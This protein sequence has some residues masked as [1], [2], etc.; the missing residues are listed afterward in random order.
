MKKNIRLGQVLLEE[1]KITEP[2]LEIALQ[3]QKETKGKRLGEI[4]IELGFIQETSML[5]SLAKRLNIDYISNFSDQIDVETTR[6]VSEALVKK[7]NIVPLYIRDGILH[8]A[9]NDPLNFYGIDDIAMS[10][11][12]EIQVSIAS[13][14]DVDDAIEKL[15]AKAGT[16]QIIDD[17]NNEYQDYDANAL[18]LEEAT[19]STERIDASPVV[20]LVNNL[21]KEAQQANASDIHVEPLKETTRVRFRIDGDLVEHQILKANVHDLLVTRIKILSGMNIAEKRIPLDGGFAIQF[22]SVKVD[23]R[24][25]TLPTIYGEKVVMR[26]LGSDASIN[27]DI[28]EL[29]LSENN[30]KFVTRATMNSNGIILVTGP[31]GSGKSTTTYSVLQKISSP[32][33]NI[34]SV[35][36]PVEK[37]FNN[38]TQVQVNS[39]V[40]LTFASGLRSI[41]RQDPDVVMIGEIRD[42]ETASIAVRAAITGHLVLSTIHTNDAISTVSRLIDMGVE[43]YLVAASVRCIISQRLVKKL[44]PHCKQKRLLTSDESKLIGEDLDYVYEPKGCPFCNSTG[45]K[46]RTA[47]H[48]VLNI[49]RVISRM[50]SNNENLDVIKAQALKN[51]M[52]TLKQESVRLLKEGFTSMDEVIKLIYS[53]E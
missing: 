20:Q 52:S 42:E 13:K 43:A 5:E 4:L 38:I 19:D 12:L 26:L 35:E 47:I 22:P 37:S 17:V 14:K 28:D 6:V 8:V 9:T 1:N 53:I 31:T 24:V 39:K 18:S 45:Y 46:G 40:G 15:Y 49:D 23:I 10:S 34:V 30:Y 33:I 3:K 25:S 29:G 7:N 27:Y 48:E 2:Q 44:C 21:V 41:L 11:G 51:N 16:R 32:K 50:I 36:D